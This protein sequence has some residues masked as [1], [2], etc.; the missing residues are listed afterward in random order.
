MTVR[1]APLL[2]CIAVAAALSL[3]SPATAHEGHGRPVVS[4]AVPLPP[5]PP[6]WVAGVL[7]PP[8]PGP[9]GQPSLTVYLAWLDANRAAYLARFGWNP[10]RVARYES[11]YRPY[12]AGLVAWQPPPPA[13]AWHRGEWRGHGGERGRGP[14]RG[15]HDD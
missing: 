12:R 11:W 15:G 1:P 2:A 8:A 9:W 13:V 10:W 6:P 7:P 4:V 5:A 3:P 14:G